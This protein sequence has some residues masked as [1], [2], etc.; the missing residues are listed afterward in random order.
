MCRR[1]VGAPPATPGPAQ[2]ILFKRGQVCCAGSRLYVE[3]KEFDNVVGGLVDAAESMNI[4]PGMD[5]ACELGPL[6]SDDQLDRRT[7]FGARGNEAAAQARTGGDPGE[8]T[9]SVY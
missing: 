9:G 6:V 5:P 2:G 4:A 8:G 3:K 7:G 1:A